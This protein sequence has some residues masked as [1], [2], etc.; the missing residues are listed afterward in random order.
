MPPSPDKPELGVIPREVKRDTAIS[1]GEDDETSR[2]YITRGH[3][4]YTHL[5]GWPF[6]D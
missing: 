4:Y 3:V 5:A 2:G 6:I 1:A